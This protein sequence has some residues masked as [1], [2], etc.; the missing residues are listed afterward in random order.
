MK[1]LFKWLLPVPVVAEVG[2]V[3]RDV[4]EIGDAILIVATVEILLLIV[5]GHRLLVAVRKYRRNRRSGLDGWKALEDGLTVLLPRV[6]ARLAVSEP[7]LFY[8]LIKWVLRKT[9]LRKGE[10]SYHKRSTFDMLILMVVLVTPIEI[11]V[12]ELLLQA[13]LPLLWLRILFLALAI[14]AVFWMLGFHASRVTLPHRLEATDLRLRHGVFAEGSIPYSGIRHA[15]RARQKAP[16][17]GDGLQVSEDGAYMAIGGNTDITLKLRSPLTLHGFFKPTR[18]VNTVYL[19]ADEPEQ[20]LKELKKRMIA[21]TPA[22]K[23]A[24]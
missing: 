15:E 22:E 24:V 23:P 9:Q 10:F 1:R 4:L 7:R 3:W 14:Y 19:A 20:L 8:C 18:P 21:T 11:L 2:L 12:V 17:W 5:G 6:A 13:F 16:E